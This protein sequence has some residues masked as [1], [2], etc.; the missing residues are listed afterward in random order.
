MK[1]YTVRGWD[2]LMIGAF[3]VVL[4]WTGLLPWALGVGILFLCAKGVESILSQD[5]KKAD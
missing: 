1:Y 5:K 3:G 2:Y 4:T